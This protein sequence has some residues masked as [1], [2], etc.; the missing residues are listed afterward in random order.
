MLEIESLH[1]CCSQANGPTGR[2]NSWKIK[3]Q[4]LQKYKYT[5]IVLK[6]SVIKVFFV[7]KQL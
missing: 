2:L 6:K 7:Y 1:N 4:K 3:I 5:K